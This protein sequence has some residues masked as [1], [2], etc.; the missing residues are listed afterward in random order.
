MLFLG[1]N[2]GNSLWLSLAISFSLFKIVFVFLL[3][4]QNLGVLEL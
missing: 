1:V 4:V 3:N 2:L